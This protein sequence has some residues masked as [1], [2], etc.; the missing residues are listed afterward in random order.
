MVARLLG[1][2]TLSA[3]VTRLRKE[4]EDWFAGLT[5]YLWAMPAVVT[6]IIDGDTVVA[7]IT[8]MPGLE[9]NDERIRAEGINA[10]ELGTTP[11]NEALEF[12]QQ[13]LPEGTKVLLTMSRRDKY[14][15]VLASIRWVTASGANMDFSAEMIRSGHAVYYST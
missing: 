10:P 15:R 8:V 12:A 3:I 9:L 7:K 5:R 14:G 11:G 1:K 13:L 2:T 6:R 4:G